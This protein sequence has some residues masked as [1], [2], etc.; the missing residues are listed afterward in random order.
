MPD[1]DV[2]A[3]ARRLIAIESV[4]QGLAKTGSGEA[5]IADFCVA[6]LE[7]RGFD[8]SRLEAT[9][10]RPSVVGVARGTGGG[11]SIMLNGHLDTVGVATYLA[12]PFD[13][14]V[15]DGRLH[16]RGSFDMKTG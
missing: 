6:W 10:G 8:V 3:L 1:S 16:G 2:L 14:V 15:R 12:D 13:P 7:T 5:A 4:N 11:R 9:P